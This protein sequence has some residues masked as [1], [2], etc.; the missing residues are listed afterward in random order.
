LIRGHIT[1]LVILVLL[2]AIGISIE[3]IGLLDVEQAL[4]F[5]REYAQQW[6]LVAILILAQALLFTFALAGSVF[7]W[8][9][10]PLYSPPMATIILAAGGT[11]GGLGAYGFS[12]FLTEDWKRKIE[13]SH[14]YKLLHTQDNF[15]TMFAMRIFPAFPHALVNYSAGVLSAKLSHFVVAAILGISI[16]SYIYARA[17]YGA[18]SS[19]SLDILLDPSIFGPLVGLSSISAI[20]VFVNYRFRRNQ[21]L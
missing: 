3:V 11:L 21:T 2:I 14:S 7:L 6:W 17:I 13:N 1:K 10:A 9:A 8:I 5:S 19:L 18:S 16:K 20:G 12:R 15:L 4:I